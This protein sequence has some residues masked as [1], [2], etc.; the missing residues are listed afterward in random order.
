MLC[1]AP[2]VR[3]C[4]QSA[5][6]THDFEGVKAVEMRCCRTD[7]YI[8]NVAYGECEDMICVCWLRDVAPL[9]CFDVLVCSAA[10]VGVKY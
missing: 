2:Q 3:F 7:G 6:F 1:L 10:R 5:E 8:P 9:T 4:L